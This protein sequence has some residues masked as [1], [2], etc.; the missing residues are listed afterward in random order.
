MHDGDAQPMAFPFR[1]AYDARLSLGKFRGMGRFLRQLIAGRE[2]DFLGLC[3]PGD[4]DRNL[5][6]ISLGPRA[7][8]AWEQI[9]IPRM[10]RQKRVDI[11]IAPYNTAPLF[12]PAGTMLVLVVHDLIFMESLPWSRSAYQNMGR[13]YRRLVVPSA[14]RRADV[15]VAVSEY[16]ARQLVHQ[17]AVEPGRIRVIPNSVS[18]EW[19]TDS[20]DQP[21]RNPYVLVVA[22]EAP[23]KNLSRA[24][25]A[26]AMC[27]QVRADRGIR[28]KIAGV[29]QSHH[30]AFQQQAQQLGIADHIDF[31]PYLPD[32]EMRDLYRQ[33]EAL[34]M[35][36]LCEGFGIPI[37]EAMASGTPVVCS[38]A[39]CLPEIGGD[40]PRYFDPYLPASIAEAITQVLSDTKLRTEMSLR[41][42]NR[43]K[44]F[45][46][47]IVRARIHSLW[48]ELRSIRR[49][50]CA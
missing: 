32:E 42:L 39:T 35:P 47:D 34:V 48:D 15:V 5:N 49:A 43:A 33:A 27:S 25:I 22:G 17:F 4:V 36:S 10:L 28:V 29:K 13:L 6:L 24:L 26:F 38:S 11:F 31:L 18:R 14:V 9:A 46:P 50:Q 23:S 12:L 1:V 30:P 3:A 37:L 45:H 19:Y 16:T 2:H 41:G 40:A 8:P 21:M 7:Y 44:A 20:I